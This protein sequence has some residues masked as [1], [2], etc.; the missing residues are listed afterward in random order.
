MP[1][2]T[3]LAVAVADVLPC[4]ITTDDVT[5]P[6]EGLVVARLT[7]SP[8]AGAGSEIDRSKVTLCPAATSTLA[9]NT[10]A[11]CLTVTFALAGLDP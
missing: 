9:G 3:P 5:V 7:V 11:F 10:M 4:G 6:M 1:L 8:P 2:L